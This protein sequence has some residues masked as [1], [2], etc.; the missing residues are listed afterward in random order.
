ME[1]H[2]SQLLSTYLLAGNELFYL[3][4]YK[5]NSYSCI[6]DIWVNLVTLF[7]TEALPLFPLL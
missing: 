2:D 5:I 7:Y 3:V 4:E 6:D 1:I